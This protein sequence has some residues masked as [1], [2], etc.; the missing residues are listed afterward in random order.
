LR[1]FLSFFEKTF[2]FIKV[3]KLIAD[4]KEGRIINKKFK[5]DKSGA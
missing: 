5:D 2:L 3:L 4:N 1:L